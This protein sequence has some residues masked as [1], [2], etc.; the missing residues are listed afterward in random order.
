MIRIFSIRFQYLTLLGK[1][2]MGDSRDSA[3][4]VLIALS[5]RLTNFRF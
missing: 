2:K 3:E 5:S 4:M 1:D